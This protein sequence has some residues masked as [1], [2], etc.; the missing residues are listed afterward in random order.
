MVKML[1]LSKLCISLNLPPKLIPNVNL[2]DYFHI[3][4][5]VWLSRK[6]ILS[7]KSFKKQ[8]L[9]LPFYHVLV[10]NR[11]AVRGKKQRMAVVPS[12]MSVIHGQTAI[13]RCV[14]EHIKGNVQW[15]KDGVLLGQ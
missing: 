4:C 11:P 13:L 12:D 9:I 15:A 5:M 3:F 10:W 14:V 6:Y 2:G 8:F 1:E 7:F